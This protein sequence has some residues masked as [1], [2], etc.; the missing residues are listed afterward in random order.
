MNPSDLIRNFGIL[1]ADQPIPTGKV[2]SEMK[3]GTIIGQYAFSVIFLGSFGLAGLVLLAV[4]IFANITFESRGI[5]IGLGVFF[6]CATAFIA[7]LA[8]AHDYQ[9]V[10]LDGETLR[11]K[12]LYSR[13]VSER[14]VKEINDILT[15]VIMIKTLAV[16]IVEKRSGRIRA[17]A[18]R[19]HDLPKGIKI[20][21]PEMTNVAELV[22]A[23][24]GAMSRHGPVEPEIINMEGSPMVRR[25]HWA[26]P[27]AQRPLD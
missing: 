5:C 4:G 16:R 13:R 25:V 27:P 12:H 17:F 1:P 8:L 18:F 7:S 20:F 19:F 2:R 26:T 6:S 21:R 23:V 24:I 3:T 22:S 10:E 14:P 9:W 15:E 11:A